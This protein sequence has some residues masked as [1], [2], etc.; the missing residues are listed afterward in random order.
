MASCICNTCTSFTNG[1]K[2]ANENSYCSHGSSFQ[3]SVSKNCKCP[4]CDLGKQAGVSHMQ[5][6]TKGSD[7]SQKFDDTHK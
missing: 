7:K 4:T 6:C 3:F 5:F 2:T 1:A